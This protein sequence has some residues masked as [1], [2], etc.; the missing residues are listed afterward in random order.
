MS[1]KLAASALLLSAGLTSAF[2]ADL[3]SR[4]S[5]P[6]APPPPSACTE[7]EGIPTD[8]FGFTT[9]S[10]VADVGS[11]GPSFTYGGAYGTRT[12]R[13][14]SNSGQ[15]Q[16][17]YGLFPCME[18]GPY[19]LGNFT[20]ASVGGISADERSFGAGVEM[21]Y[22][23]LGRDLHGI[24]LTAVVDPSFNRI[25]PEGAG[26]FTV[27]NTGLRLFADKTLIPGKLYAALNVS[28]DMTWTGPDPYGRSSTLTLGGSL[29]WQ[30]LDGVYLSGEVRHQRAYNTLGFSKEAGYATFAGPGVYWQATKALAISAAYNVQLAG[31]AKG[32]PGNLDL[33]NFSQHLLKVKV[34]YSF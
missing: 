33:T 20:N 1:L 28:Q 17:S 12:G 4:K 10:D 9:G 14:N 18:V 32:E 8:A 25:D 13:L 23:L 19:L 21:K 2:A 5:A 24:G 34:S 27:Y 22:K 3:P 31:K 7:S 15:L 11:F 29:A 30:V 16:G 6:A 26:R